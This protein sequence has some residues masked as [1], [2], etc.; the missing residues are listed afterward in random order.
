MKIRNLTYLCLALL[1]FSACNKDKL[2]EDLLTGHWNLKN[3]LIDDNYA[4]FEIPHPL[5]LEE[6]Q[7]TKSLESGSWSFDKKAN[8]LSLEN[9]DQYDVYT[10]LELSPNTLRLEIEKEQF[11][12]TNHIVEVYFKEN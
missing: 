7:Y 11:G 10:I 2:D 1:C 3:I 5:I 8:T 6:D 12:E 4:I 9:T